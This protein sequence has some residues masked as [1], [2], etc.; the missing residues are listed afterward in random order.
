MAKWKLESA[1]VLAILIL[2]LSASGRNRISGADLKP[3]PSGDSAIKP[4]L[5]KFFFHSW[6]KGEYKVCQTYSGAPGV[7]VCDSDDDIEWKSSLMNLIAAN[8]REGKTEEQSYRE[9]LAF[10]SAHG[11]SFLSV[12]SED[13]WPKPQTGFR[14]SVW[15]CT[16]DKENTV[17]CGLGG[18]TNKSATA[19]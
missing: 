10:A 14:L 3:A 19:E 13:P 1:A 9:A 7:V 11:K 2:A 15:N 12:F 6:R 5:I 16:K 17:S 18:R 4:E 8:N